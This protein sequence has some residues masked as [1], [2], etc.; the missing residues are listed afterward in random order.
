MVSGAASWHRARVA[1]VAFPLA[2]GAHADVRMRLT[3]AGRKLLR[4]KRSVPVVAAI[5][6]ATATGVNA[7]QKVKFTLVR[8]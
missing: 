6:V 1:T 8:R 5:K 2:S 3:S 7:T 4:S